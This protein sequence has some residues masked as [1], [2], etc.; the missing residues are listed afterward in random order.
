M[1][2]TRVVV[3]Y[4]GRSTEHEVSC[5]SA[6]FV[7]RN[8]DPAKYEIMAVAIDKSGRWLPQPTEDLLVAIKRGD[9]FVPIIQP[10]SVSKIGGS[11]Q[12]TVDPVENMRRAAAG[13]LSKST[14]KGSDGNVTKD[15]VSETVVFPV[16][17]GTFGE[18]GSVQ[19]F[20]DLADM[21]YVGPGTLGSAIGMDK[22]VAKKLAATAGIP[23]VPW[24]DIRKQDWKKQ[25]QDVCRRAIA[26]LG[27]P[28]F[29][30]PATL[31]SS[32]GVSKVKKVEDLMPACEAALEFDDRLLIEKGLEVREIECAMLGDYDPDV[33]VPGEV[34]AHTDFY[35]YDAKYISA[36]A[37]SIAIPA[38][39]TE[40]QT[41]EAQEMSRRVF[42]ALELYGMA[43]VDLF[44]EKGTGKFYLNEVNTIPG[45][46]EISQ[47]PMLWK[48]SGVPPAA[49]LDRLVDL[50]IRRRKMRSALK[51]SVD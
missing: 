7:L 18:D 1:S 36:D 35:S 21:A 32:V 3:L 26:D 38:K 31:G 33:S 19:G 27:L 14:F 17:H 15:T 51:R 30:K 5:R 39:L 8:L 11:L 23:V 13:D 16:L 24:V 20:F 4:G 29:V 42:V 28:L 6:A 34:I 41:K 2:K 22:V 45:F 37:A 10:S 9:R 47:Y 49:L 48:E 46:T 43:R 12:T 40:Q 25:G 44:L 50:A